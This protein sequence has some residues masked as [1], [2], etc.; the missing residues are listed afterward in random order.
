MNLG[1]FMVVTEDTPFLDFGRAGVP[2]ITFGKPSAEGCDYVNGVDLGVAGCLGHGGEGL[3]V[4]GRGFF[5]T[6]DDAVLDVEEE[7]GYF[8]GG[9]GRFAWFEG[10]KSVLEKWF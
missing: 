3:E 9:H 2:G 4:L 1:R 6:V 8:L 5:E 10:M 7:E